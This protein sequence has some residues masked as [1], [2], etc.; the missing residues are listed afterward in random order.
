MKLKDILKNVDYVATGNIDEIPVKEI[1][2]NSRDVGRGSLFVAVKGFK[3]DGHH[4]ID[5]ASKKGAAAVIM[6]KG[7]EPTG[8]VP[9]VMVED[10]RKILPL[11]SK[12]FFNDPTREL[13]IAGVT[14]TNGKTT[15]V[16]IID[17]IL[18]ASGLK[19][20]M[21]T[22][23][24]SFIGDKRVEFE[25]TTPESLELNKFFYNSR[26]SGIKH[27]AMEV[28]SH[29]VDLGRTDYLNFNCFVFTNLTQDHLDYHLDMENYFEV[30]RRLFI[31]SYRNVFRS[32]HAVINADDE[33][34][35]RLIIDTDLNKLTYSIMSR[36]ADLHAF[37][38]KNEISGITM[39]VSIKGRGKINIESRLCGFFNV[40]NILGAIGAALSLKINL[41]SIIAG[42][43]NMKGVPGRFE[44]IEN[45]SG[46][47]AIVDYAH[48]PGGL[49]SVLK[50]ARS[51]LKKG[52]RLI[53][54][55]GC[56]GDRDK[57]KR[58]EMGIIA[59]KNADFTI[60]T[61]DNPR[62]EDPQVIMDMV[63]EGFKTQGDVFY[64]KI[65]NRK[66]AIE[67]A[68]SDAR[69]N[70]IVLIAGKG[71]EDYQEFSDHR[72]HFSDQEVVR[73]WFDMRGQL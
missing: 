3:L 29:A 65:I 47:T 36:H 13:E 27:C 37:D 69:K 6:E 11:I 57:A 25:R 59:A 53:G 55:F 56:G 23:V 46:F 5:D 10:T 8:S 61:S 39:T 62:T 50:T 33:Y 14:G 67:R 9:F 60:I 16:F 17:S 31:E 20:S 21:I 51:L 64:D 35:K 73:E 18:K 12:N 72:L 22:T 54:V 26:L 7:R 34:G 43:R 45:H 52:S 19:T 40:Y 42:I 28:S 68:L 38:I 4:Y 71:H 30:K 32:S 15:T 58:K 2:I 49:E 70:D 24:D 1:T 41:E 44:R 66:E 48:T 63:E